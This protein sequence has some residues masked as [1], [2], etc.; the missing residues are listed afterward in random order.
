MSTHLLPRWIA[1]DLRRIAHNGRFAAFSLILP[2]LFFVIFGIRDDLKTYHYPG[3]NATAYVMVSMAV[4]ASAMAST[5]AAAQISAER[6]QGWV[7]QLR[8]LPPSLHSYVVV[9]VAV[10]AV[11]AAISE[12]PVF[13]LGALL[14]A[15]M[16][17]AGWILCPIVCWLGSMMFAAFGVVIGF[18]MRSQNAMQI[19]GPGLTLLAALGGLFVPIN[20][21]PL[22]I[23]SAVSPL[24]GVG[25]LARQ[26]IVQSAD[27]AGAVV[28]LTVWLIAAVLA[29]GWAVSRLVGRT[30]R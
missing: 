10:A 5:S 23:V 25:F 13:A 22:Q 8:A 24:Y 1:L 12:I 2:A 7:R 29:S 15:Q 21:G 6:W 20:S 28:N 18:T 27:V 11:Q 16:N 4:Y 30:V 19:V 9:R 17:A 14:G 26:P 3:G